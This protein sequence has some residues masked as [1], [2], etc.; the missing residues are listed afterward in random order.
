MGKD[1]IVKILVQHVRYISAFV[2]SPSPFALLI[3][4]WD[5]LHSIYTQVRE[6]SL[7]RIAYDPDECI[8]SPNHGLHCHKAALLKPYMTQ[9][10]HLPLLRLINMQPMRRHQCIKEH[11][12]W[13]D[14]RTPNCTYTTPRFSEV[15][16][17]KKPEP[18][19][20]VRHLVV[21][22]R[23]LCTW[24]DILQEML[25]CLKASC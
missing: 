15:H 22:R 25:L 13:E 5:R 20:G 12:S 18:M 9:E 16:G 1:S 2:P 3:Y 19:F 10:V 21:S 24:F 17:Q 4:F 6:Y 8:W 23:K 14:C 11:R 7:L